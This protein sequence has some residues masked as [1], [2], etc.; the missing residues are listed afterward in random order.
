MASPMRV[1]ATALAC[2]LI[3]STWELENLE[4]KI[5]QEAAI[6][7][8]NSDSS[9]LIFESTSKSMLSIC[10]SLNH[11]IAWNK[12]TTSPTSTLYTPAKLM[13]LARTKIP[14]SSWRQIPT[15]V[16]IWA[17]EKTASMLLKLT[18]NLMDEEYCC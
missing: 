5:E 16:R 8:P 1:W 6:I 17:I 10:I 13:V 12:R 11:C 14:S 15:P 9:F 7:W 3:N 2:R 4:W 18:Q